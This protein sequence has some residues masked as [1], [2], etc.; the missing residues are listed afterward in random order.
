MDR[1][2]CNLWNH[3][4]KDYQCAISPAETTLKGISAG[5]RGLQEG[6]IE[7]FTNLGTADFGVWKVEGG[8]EPAS[9][10]RTLA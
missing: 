6:Y 8:T 1:A 4:T 7:L 5:W 2:V 9:V 10:R 3:P